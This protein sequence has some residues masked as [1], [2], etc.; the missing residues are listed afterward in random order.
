M[1]SNKK[2]GNICFCNVCSKTSKRYI[3][4]IC[5]RTFHSTGLMRQSEASNKS[6]HF[7]VFSL[8]T[9]LH[10]HYICRTCMI[11]WLIALHSNRSLFLSEGNLFLLLQ[12]SVFIV[13]ETEFVPVFLI[14]LQ[15]FALNIF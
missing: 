2:S 9:F 8:T 14:L 11:S 10:I 7:T 1:I 13:L 12:V 5:L 6:S 4:I 15:D 3:H